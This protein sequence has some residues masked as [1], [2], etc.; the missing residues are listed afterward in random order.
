MNKLLSTLNSLISIKLQFGGAELMFDTFKKQLLDECNKIASRF[1]DPTSFC[2]YVVKIFSTNELYET[3]NIT[4]IYD[5]NLETIATIN[6]NEH[7]ASDR[8]FVIGLYKNTYSV[9]IPELPQDGFLYYRHKDGSI[10]FLA[11][12]RNI[13]MRGHIL[14]T[15]MSGLREFNAGNKNMEYIASNIMLDLIDS[16]ITTHE[17]PE[18]ECYGKEQELNASRQLMLEHWRTLDDY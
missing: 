1:I 10:I 17:D 8:L 12:V 6:P 18:D 3:H 2:D 11:H 14:Y 7:S 15:E 13:E 5:I 16:F 9:S 4:T